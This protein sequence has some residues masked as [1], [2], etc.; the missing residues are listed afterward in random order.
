MGWAWG[1]AVRRYA[2]LVPHPRS[3]F[4]R[5]Y[6]AGRIVRRSGVPFEVTHLADQQGAQ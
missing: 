1:K 3:A 6:Q 4:A 2:P 5:A